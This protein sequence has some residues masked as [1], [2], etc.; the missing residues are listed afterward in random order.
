MTIENDDELAAMKRVGQIVALTMNGMARALRPGMTTAELDEVGRDLL[1]AH[2]ARSAP[3]LMYGFPGHTCIS[4]N[5]EA[6]HGI[7]SPH[8]RIRAGDLVNIDV[9]AELDGF[10]G[11]TGGSFPV[12]EVS[13]QAEALC[14]ATRSALFDGIAAAR[15]GKPLWAIGK[16][17]QARAKARGFHVIRNLAGHGIG[18]RLHESPSVSNTFDSRNR[19]PLWEGL[20][21]TIEPFL[22]TRATYVEEADDGWTLK[23]PD[24]SLPAQYEHTMVI[25]KDCPILLTAI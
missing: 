23:T 20:V 8:R 4:I 10:F 9:S 6:A 17:V 22:S 13:R 16:A 15:A 12:G 18:R 21:I 24:G 3:K 5:D 1:S 2:G 11:D 14:A 7:P 25:T 19:Q